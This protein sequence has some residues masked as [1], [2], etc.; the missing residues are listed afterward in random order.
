MSAA[1]PVLSSG[2]VSAKAGVAPRREGEAHGSL[3]ARGQ[4]PYSIARARRELAEQLRAAGLDSPDLDARILIGHT[5]GLDH[6]AL[7]V[8]SDTILTAGELEIVA[9]MAA[10]RLAN[11]PVARIIGVKEF[12]GLPLHLNS[13]TLVPRPETETVVEAALDALGEKQA[14]ER[15]WRVADLGTGSGALALALLTELP[16]AWAVGTDISPAALACAR[17]NAGALGPGARAAFVGSNFGAALRGPFDLVV[18]NPPYVCRGDIATLAPEVRE[19]DPWRAL[20]G[21][22][23]GLTAYRALAADARRLL[24]TGGVLVAELGAGQRSA[25][26]ALFVAAGLTVV[27]PPR[28]DLAGIERALV[29]RRAP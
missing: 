17:A 18:C 5:L 22:T 2:I 19:H 3:L 6:A 13:D 7:A 24:G 12:W 1:G 20:D 11:E 27:L 25:V 26:E 14:R 28:R 4:Q 15:P 8:R 23:D 9:N 16:A 21:G 10:R 29:V